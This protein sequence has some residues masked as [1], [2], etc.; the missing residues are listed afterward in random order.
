MDSFWKGGD[1]KMKKIK[2]KDGKIIIIR[3]ADKPDASRILEYMNTISCE[4]DFL[5]FGEGEFRMSVEQ[6]EKF[7]DDISKQD[8]AIFLIAEFEGKIIGNLS[9]MGGP[10]AR[11]AHTG[12]FGVSVL[13]DY[14]SKG[15]GTELIKYLIDWCK[16]SKIIR[17][18]NLKV[19]TDNVLAI[20][21]YKKMG[22]EVEGRITR[23]SQINGIFYDAL[24]MGLIID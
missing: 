4:S 21:V 1:V 3:R 24:F 23:D 2:L 11:I 13:K 16:S 22:F 17:K 7:I 18:V 20:H 9:F 8:N 15:L 19:R 5:T 6:E 12:E 14:W 10:R